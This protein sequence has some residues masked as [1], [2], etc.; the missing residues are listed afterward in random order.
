MK[1]PKVIRLRTNTRFIKAVV[2]AAGGMGPF[3]KHMKIKTSQVHQWTAGLRPVPLEKCIE[4]ERLTEGQVTRY[5]LRPELFGQPRPVRAVYK[6]P[7]DATDAVA[8][9]NRD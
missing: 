5:H 2:D 4:I 8:A 3:A 9:Q 1:K 7:G 6:M